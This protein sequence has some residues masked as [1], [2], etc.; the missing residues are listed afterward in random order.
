MAFEELNTGKC[1]QWR[2]GS[3]VFIGEQELYRKVGHGLF[4]LYSGKN[5]VIFYPCSETLIKAEFKSN[6]IINFAEDIDIVKFGLPFLL[7]ALLLVC[8][9]REQVQKKM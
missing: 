1:G 2:L 3:R 9:G 6:E 7:A 4:V 5:L 8:L